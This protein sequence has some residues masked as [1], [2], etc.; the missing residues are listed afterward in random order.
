MTR[1][2][3]WLLGLS[4]LAACG[5][6]EKVRP[7]DMSAAQHRQEAAREQRA[8]DEHELKYDPTAIKGEPVRAMKG[9]PED[10]LYGEKV[11]DPEAHHLR[12]AQA[13]RAHSAEHQRAAA[14]LE[15]FEQEECKDFPAAT[16][17]SCPLLGPATAIIDVS[18]GVRVD[19]A[20]GVSVEAVA[21][22]MRCHYAYARAHGFSSAVADCPLY[23][24]GIAIRITGDGRAIEITGPDAETVERI[25]RSA[26]EEAIPARPVL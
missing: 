8:A 23:L 17:A 1:L 15:K 10:Y 21:A 20:E 5:G 9:G 7:D 19:F 12:D 22:L 6:G 2:A 14:E 26:R 11:Y 18:H 3:A 13:H 25:R 4:V 16:R 24:P